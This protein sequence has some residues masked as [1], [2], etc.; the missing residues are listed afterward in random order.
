[1]KKNKR[2]NGFILLLVVTMIPL[3]GMVLAIMTTNSKSLMI[4]TRREEL[5]ARAENACQSGLAW[6]RQNPAKVKSLAAGKTIPL[7]IE[8]KGKQI[9][10]LIE[11]LPQ[12]EDQYTLQITGHAEDSLFSA[13]CRQQM[14]FPK[15]SP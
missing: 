13:E 14:S 3:I 15:V 8:N 6:V 12:S 1:M 10:C 9:D 4:Q 2:K 5:H 7:T 11:E